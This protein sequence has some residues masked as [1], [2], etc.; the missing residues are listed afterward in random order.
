MTHNTR[1]RHSVRFGAAAA[2]ALMLPASGALAQDNSHDAR[3]TNAEMQQQWDNMREQTVQGSEILRGEYTPGLDPIME[4]DNL[5]LNDAGTAIEYVVVDADRLPWELYAEDGYVSWNAVDLAGGANVNDVNLTGDAGEELRGPEQLRITADEA[6]R[7]LV[8]RVI[9]SQ[10][11][12]ADGVHQIDDVLVHPETG[13]L[14]H[15]VVGTT[16]DNVFSSERRATP[17]DQVSWNDGS[18]RTDLTRNEIMQMDEYDPG[19]L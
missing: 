13:R 18:L 15:Y 8:S 1:F 10:V 2:A 11:R 5:V 14:T 17:V 6:D 4:I 16:D 19:F 12:T 7:R 3:M 9:D